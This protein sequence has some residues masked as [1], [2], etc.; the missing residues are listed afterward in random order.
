MTEQSGIFTDIMDELDPEKKVMEDKNKN[1]KKQ[2]S[3]DEGKNDSIVNHKNTSKFDSKRNRSN[4][5][6]SL[7]VGKKDHKK[8][9]KGIY[10][11]EDIYYVLTDLV[12][13]EGGG[14]RNIQS[15]IVNDC[16]REALENR[17][18]L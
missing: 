6:D 10:F 7:S 15:K 2:E 1:K 13:Q 18:L 11:E 9:Y 3:K 4:V 14:R 8:F 16:L 12:K 5:L 17:N